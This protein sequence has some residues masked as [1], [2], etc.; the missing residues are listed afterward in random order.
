MAACYGFNSSPVYCGNC[1]SNLHDAT[2]LTNDLAV[3]P[4]RPGGKVR[5]SWVTTIDGGPG[6][7]GMLVFTKRL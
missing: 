5:H 2:L 6:R 7:F 1:P 4:M 3:R